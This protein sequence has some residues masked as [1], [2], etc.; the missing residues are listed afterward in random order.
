MVQGLHGGIP[1]S[2]GEFAV[3]LRTRSHR[4]PLFL[5]LMPM[6]FGMGSPCG[7]SVLVGPHL[8][9]NEGCHWWLL[10]LL[11][12]HSRLQTPTGRARCQKPKGPSRED[13][14]VR[15]EKILERKKN[16]TTIKPSNNKKFDKSKLKVKKKKK[17]IFKK[18]EGHKADYSPSTPNKNALA[19]ILNFCSSVAST[20]MLGSSFHNL[21]VAGMKHLEY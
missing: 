11:L 13:S 8:I 1:L 20:I 14:P 9:T 17:K 15:K 7:S 19:P 16:T 18:T 4:R 2:R 21:V 12:L 6:S 3:G 10:L 5:I